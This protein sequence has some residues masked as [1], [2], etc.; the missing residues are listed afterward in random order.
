MR[1]EVFRF[2]EN[3]H[4]TVS[5]ILIGGQFVCAGLEDQHNAPKVN[6]ETRIP[7][8]V[9]NIIPRAFGGFFAR[10]QRRFDPRSHPFMLEIESVPGFTDILIHIGNFDTDTA[11]CLLVGMSFTQNGSGRWMLRDSQEAYLLFYN[12]VRDAI[13][14]G[15]SVLIEFV[16]DFI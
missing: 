7:A 13:I 15:E 8:G 10:Y 1:I 4:E 6:G 11:G 16:D 14:R 9:Y 2:L 12:Q 3:E 5:R